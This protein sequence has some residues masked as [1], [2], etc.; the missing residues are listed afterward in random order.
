MACDDP[1]YASVAE[2]AR[3]IEGRELSP[4]E[5]VQG[6]L[7]RI[8][9]LEP[10]LN[11]FL[12]VFADQA[13][14][15]ARTAEREIAAGDYRGPL[16]GIPVGLKDIIDVAGR[17]TTGGAAFLRDNVAD[18]DATVTTRL[19]QAGAVIMGKLNLVEFA[20]GA[21]G[22]NPHYGNTHNPWDPERVTAGSS[23]GSAASVAA[24]MLAGALG[25]DTGGS[26][27]MPAALCGIAGLKP[28]YGFVPR[29]GVLPVS[30]SCD[31]VGPMARRAGD[32]AHMMNALAGQDPRDPASSGEPVPDFTSG[33]GLGLDGIRIGVPGHFFFD[34]LEP[35]IG[36][37]V[38]EALALMERNGAGLIDLPMPWVSKGRAINTALVMPEAVSVHEQWI[39]EHADRY[40]A[41]VRARIQA[42][43]SIPAVEYVRA[44]RARRWFCERMTEAMRDVD[45]LVTPTVPVR[46][47]TIE[48]CT[49]PPGA[50]EGR[51]GSRLPVFTGVFNTTGQPSLSV[52][53]GFTEDGVPIGMMVT[54]K[55][56]DDAT[57]LRVGDAYERLAGWH[58]R[59]PAL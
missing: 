9:R 58:E 15:D 51:E 26:I 7:D 11:A 38:R 14:E 27:R 30:W 55:A 2:L 53:C 46:T 4:V 48:A 23:T 24:G 28:T 17:P 25:S 8:E 56:F 57:V 20:M 54:G 35:E 50:N 52:P 3:L 44:Q 5:L 37:A 12:D 22:L 34:D 31:H 39:A 32:C 40:S 13:L 36:P 41:E 18:R 49:P 6:A 33:L 21:T 43:F 1:A 47:P 19:R 59:H 42:S 45:V 16:H 10:K 29:S